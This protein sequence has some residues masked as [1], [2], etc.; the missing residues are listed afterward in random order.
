MC[1][2]LRICFTFMVACQLTLCLV[3]LTSSVFLLPPPLTGLHLLWFT[4]VLVPALSISLVNAD[5]DSKL[6][7]TMTAKNDKNL[8]VRE[9]CDLELKQTNLNLK[10]R[11]V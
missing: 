2:G 8:K 5:N 11:T 4:C 3:M 1:F 6:M 9:I 10:V 7:T